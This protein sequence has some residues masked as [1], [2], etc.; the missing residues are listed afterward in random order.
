YVQG[1]QKHI[2]KHHGRDPVLVVV[3]TMARSMS[4]LDENNAGDAGMYLDLT[5]TIRAGLNC[6]IVT[7]AHSGKDAGRGLRG[8][9]AFVAGF[10]AV[11]C[12]EKNETTKTVKLEAEY[13]KD[14][15]DL[16]PFCFRLEQVYVEGMQ[17]S[18]AVL[19]PV[20]LT[21][22]KKATAAS[23]ARTLFAWVHD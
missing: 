1:I 11:W 9:T 20:P 23:E 6:T 7:I 4:G 13:L 10:D 17:G 8:S 14:A 19:E 3:D 18:G 12:M 2:R 16:K 15:D 22:H 5:E 21:E